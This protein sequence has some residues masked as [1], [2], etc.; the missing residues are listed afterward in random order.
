MRTPPA[1]Q[2]EGNIVAT[3][4][5]AEAVLRHFERSLIDAGFAEGAESY[6]RLADTLIGQR[7]WAESS[8]TASNAPFGAVA[9]RARAIHALLLPYVD[10][11]GRLAV[12]SSPSLL[13]ADDRAGTASPAGTPAGP[14]TPATPPSS[15]ASEDEGITP[16][17]DAVA[18]AVLAAVDAAGRPLSLTALRATL[19]VPRPELIAAVDRLVLAGRVERRNASGRELLSRVAPR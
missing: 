15:A 18:A 7:L 1:R 2:L 8:G 10:A 14:A 16:D 3:V 19:D 5:T 13:A 11:F 6:T 9:A 12:L 4:S 17:G